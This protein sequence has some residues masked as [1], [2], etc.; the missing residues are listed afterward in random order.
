MN[1][2]AASADIGVATGP[3]RAAKLTH[4]RAPKLT[5]PGRS[6]AAAK[7]LMGKA[8]SSPPGAGGWVTFGVHTRANSRARRSS[9]RLSIIERLDSHTGRAGAVRWRLDLGPGMRC[10]NYSRIS[11]PGLTVIKAKVIKV[12]A[13]SPPPRRLTPAD[14]PVAFWGIV[15][16]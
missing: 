16:M 11:E 9:E 13:A 5:H 14:E 1:D 12:V 15:I 3:R 4:L 6:A 8:L 10:R 7:A 2:S